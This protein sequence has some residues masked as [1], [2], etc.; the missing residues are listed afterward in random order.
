M[1]NLLKIEFM[2]L[3]KSKEFWYIFLGTGLIS[4][5]L[6]CNDIYDMELFIKKMTTEYSING[7]S[8]YMEGI[9]GKLYVGILQ[10]IIVI[11][12]I[13]KDFE[14][15]IVQNEYLAGYSRF[16]ILMSKVIICIVINI[17]LEFFFV[18][19]RTIGTSSLYGLGE[20]LT[21]TLVLKMLKIYLLSTL[22]RFSIITVAI[23]IAY[24]FKTISISI[25]VW[26]GVFFGY[27]IGL[28]VLTEVFKSE[29][30]L[31]YLA[32]NSIFQFY[33]MLKLDM[34]LEDILY[35][36]SM[37]SLRIFVILIITYVI[38]RKAELR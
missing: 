6:V 34:L 33:N 36:I 24:I 21:F 20:S 16:E 7:L 30:S 19:V 8:V 37:S 3:R 5:G 23:M 12:F 32:N 25:L 18:F 29:Q 31:Q 4:I 13:C 10:S 35:I 2:K 28:E 14:K 1:Y 11:I 27:L 38:F 17:I 9:N 22:I 15:R 26:L